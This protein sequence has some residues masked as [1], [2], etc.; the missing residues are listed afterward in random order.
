MGTRPPPLAARESV[1]VVAIV[2]A[3]YQP[4]ADFAT[5]AKG[6]DV[7]A[8]K[9]AA[10]G[11]GLGL[12]T[13]AAAT[14]PYAPIFLAIAAVTT[15]AMTAAG[16]VVGAINAVPAEKAKKIDATIE[17]SRAVRDLQLAL[18][19]EVATMAKGMAQFSF[20]TVNAAG[21]INASDRPGYTQLR[22][23]GVGSVLEVSVKRFGLNNCGEGLLPT[24]PEHCTK[25]KMLFFVF[26]SARL[27]KV[28]DGSEIFS[29]EFNY[30]SDSYDDD[31]W[32]ENEGQ[33][34]AAEF[35]RAYQ[36]IARQMLETLDTAVLTTPLELSAS[37][38]SES[39][40]WS[41]NPFFGLCWLA[42]EYPALSPIRGEEN[43][44]VFFSRAPD[45]CSGT[46]IHFGVVD[47]LQPT[48]RWSPFPR[49]IDRRTLDPKSLAKIDQITYDLKIWA[50]DGCARGPLV[51]E[52]V[53]LP[54]AEHKMEEP[55]KPASRYF[56]SVRARFA[57]AG[58]SMAT[59]W[60]QTGLQWGEKSC[61]AE[62]LTNGLYHR[63]VT[64]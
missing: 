43:V 38:S 23:S 3:K 57:F 5:F 26:T 22:N 58:Q 17:K 39:N 63:F 46:N 21:P 34:I 15:V 55:L 41:D 29:R 11:A 50:V 24:W 53:G 27:I 37:S 18:A 62:F 59:R 14:G 42:P 44:T 20:A 47:N 31:K 54:A 60:A 48:F 4:E 40:L 10:T 45:L 6:R 16:A 1:G 28:S 64:P 9:A 51:Y 49:D 30:L 35:E 12:T 33:S 25:G 56:W 19:G 2:P 8:A 61:F 32:L 52:R 36:E 7:G 13:A